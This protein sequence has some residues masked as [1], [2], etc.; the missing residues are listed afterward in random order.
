[1]NLRSRLQPHTLKWSPVSSATSPSEPRTEIANQLLIVIDLTSCLAGSPANAGCEPIPSSALPCNQAR[2][3]VGRWVEG[4]LSDSRAG[5]VLAHCQM[6]KLFTE[7]L[8]VIFGTFL[9][10]TYS[11]THTAW[12][13]C[14]GIALPG[15]TTAFMHLCLHELALLPTLSFAL[16]LEWTGK[17]GKVNQQLTN[18]GKLLIEDNLWN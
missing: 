13:T 3:T 5:L 17:L 9:S 11:C 6:W 4:I 15:M 18:V 14:N 1:M 7:M 8:F 2:I 16:Q 12:T 10:H